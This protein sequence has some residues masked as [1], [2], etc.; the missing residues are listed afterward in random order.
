MNK[1]LT[2]LALLVLAT[3]TS[4]LA[5]TPLELTFKGRVEPRARIQIANQVTGVVSAVHFKPGQRIGRGEPMYSI[6]SR[7]FEI[8]VAAAKAALTEAEARYALAKDRS[9]RQEELLSRGTGPQAKATETKLEAEMAK[10]GVAH[11]EA[12]LA[13]AELALARTKIS[14]PI[15]GVAHSKVSAGAFVE[16]EGGTCS[17]KSCR[18][19]LS[20]SPT[21]YPIPT[22]RRP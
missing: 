7:S 15:S 8:D 2:I 19:I 10:A 13:S 4:V 3:P 5:E 17:A 6:D 21:K 18:P 22:V 9:D 16:A 12:A 20:S 11:A 14:A 1:Y